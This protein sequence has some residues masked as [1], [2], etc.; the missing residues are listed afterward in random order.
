MYMGLYVSTVIPDSSRDVSIIHY[1]ITCVAAYNYV[2]SC[3]ATNSFT[4]VR[5]LP[6][7]SGSGA[8][9]EACNTFPG[10]LVHGLQCNKLQKAEGSY[11]GS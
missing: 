11:I 4:A 2:T 5:V 10:Y 6:F 7:I 8:D 9:L 1:A 3:M